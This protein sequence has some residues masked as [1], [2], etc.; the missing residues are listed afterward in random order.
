M[1]ATR[2]SKS[3]ATMPTSTQFMLPDHSLYLQAIAAKEAQ[4]KRMFVSEVLE[5]GMR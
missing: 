5:I 3:L 4:V 2:T 1:E